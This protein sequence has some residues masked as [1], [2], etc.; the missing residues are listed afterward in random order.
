MKIKFVEK[1]KGQLLDPQKWEFMKDWSPNG[2][3]TWV[4]KKSLKSYIPS[5]KQR[6]GSEEPACAPNGTIREHVWAIHLLW[7]HRTEDLP[8]KVSHWETLSAV[9]KSSS[10]GTQMEGTHGDHLRRDLSTGI[11]FEGRGGCGETAR[12]SRKYSG[13][14]LVTEGCSYCP[15]T[16][17]TGALRR[18][19]PNRRC[20]CCPPQEEGIR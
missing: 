16:E 17:E 11:G 12:D 6:N 19:L 3:I 4:R 2:E 8:D 10:N 1:A 9:G 13:L 20:D 18:G 5:S 7:V 14:G 15:Q